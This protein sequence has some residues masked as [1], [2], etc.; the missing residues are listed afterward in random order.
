M[1]RAWFLRWLS[2][3]AGARPSRRCGP[4]PP[5]PSPCRSGLPWLGSHFRIDALSAFLSCG[6]RISRRRCRQ[7]VCSRLWAARGSAIARAAVLSGL[8][9]RHEPGRG[10]PTDALHLPG[11]LG[12]HVALVMGR[13]VMSHH[14]IADNVRAGYVYLVHGEPSARLRAAARLRPAGRPPTACTVFEQIACRPHRST[15]VAALVLCLVLVG[16]RLPR[17]AWYR[18]MSGCRS[19]TRRPP[20]HV[21]ALMSGR[22]DQGRGLR[23]RCASCSTCWAHR[24]GGGSMVVLHG[25][26][27]VTAVLG[28]LYALIAAGSQTTSWPTAPSRIS[29]SSSS[30]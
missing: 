14:R 28:V 20:S 22:D 18:C 1:A 10:S 23:I 12:I 7:P 13:W 9:R 8:S 5:R 25:R 19:P 26:R 30:G 11:V 16:N 15:G 21:S 6:G 29:A 24:P 4:R 2:L 3:A 27:P 17:P